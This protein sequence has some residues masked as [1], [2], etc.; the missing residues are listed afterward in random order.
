MAITSKAEH[1]LALQKEIVED[2]LSG[3]QRTLGSLR[4]VESPGG[5]KPAQLLRIGGTEGKWGRR[6]FITI[7]ANGQALRLYGSQKKLSEH[8]EGAGYLAHAGNV[9]EG[10]Q[11]DLPCRIMTEPGRNGFINVAKVLPPNGVR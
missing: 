6:L 2:F 3:A 10:V 7:Q 5:G 1:L 9:R 11:L 4:V 8:L